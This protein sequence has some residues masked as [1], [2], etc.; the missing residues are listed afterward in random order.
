MRTPGSL[1]RTPPPHRRDR[2]RCAARA[3]RISAASIAR[4]NWQSI[5]DAGNARLVAVASRDQAKAQAFIDACQT[6]VPHPTK[7][8]ALGSYEALLAR[9]DIDAV[10]VPLPTG[11]KKEWVIRAARAGKH[12]LVEKPVGCVGADV[13]EMIAACAQHDVQFM[14]GVMFM[15]GLIQT[16][17]FS[18]DT[19]DCSSGI[20]IRNHDEELE[21]NW[22]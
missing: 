7:P 6:Q 11:L 1:I 19:C 15:H 4:K 14:D 17:E 8:E 13:A 10:Y 18:P 2:S 9:P 12:V 16:G 20:H 22:T 3:R 21:E 5:R